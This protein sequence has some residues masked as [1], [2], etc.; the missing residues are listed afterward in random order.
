MLEQKLLEQKTT[1]DINNLPRG[2]YIVQ[3]MD[4][5]AGLL[6]AAKLLIQRQ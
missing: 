3:T 4:K 2:L 6:D 1:I 5:D